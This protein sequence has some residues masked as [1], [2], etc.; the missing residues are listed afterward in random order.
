[1]SAK[2]DKDNKSL[3]WLLYEE[4]FTLEK[5]KLNGIYV[6]KIMWNRKDEEGMTVYCLY[7]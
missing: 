7:R 3:E 5:R 6:Y 2:T 1:M 4:S